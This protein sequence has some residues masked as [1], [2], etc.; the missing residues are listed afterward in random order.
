M[1]SCWNFRCVG[2]RV[3]WVFIGPFDDIDLFN[4]GE[5]DFN[6]LSVVYVAPK[7]YLEKERVVVTVHDDDD[8]DGEYLLNTAIPDEVE[9]EED[10]E[11]D[12]EH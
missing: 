4:L 2:E 12:D 6:M 9:N 1:E 10:Q 7:E 5:I 3:G 8:N 11:E